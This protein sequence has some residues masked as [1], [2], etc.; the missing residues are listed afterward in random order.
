MVRIFISYSEDDGKILAKELR[1]YLRKF[2]HEVFVARH[3]I[4][5]GEIW[6]QKIIDSLRT[7]DIFIVLLTSAALKSGFVS[8]EITMAKDLNKIIIPCKDDLL[9][10]SWGELPLDLGDY[11]GMDFH[12]EDELKRRLLNQIEGILKNKVGFEATMTLKTEKKSYAIGETIKVVGTVPAIIEEVPVVLQVF[13]PRNWR[14]AEEQLLPYTDRTFV[15]E[16]LIEGMIW[17]SGTYNVRATYAG[18]T[19]N[20]TFEFT[21]EIPPEVVRATFSGNSVDIHA[22]LSNGV[23]NNVE[24]DPDFTSIII[25]TTTSRTHQGELTITL[26]RNLIDT[27]C[28]GSGNDDEFIILIDGEE[29]TYKE[30]ETTST[31]RTLLIQVPSGA[32]EIEIIGTQVTGV[33]TNRS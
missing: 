6:K 24:V 21:K 19:V 8:M 33:G 4:Q 31:H 27:K 3:D 16:F 26:P 9:E 25:C 15:F 29:E 2:D 1:G 22:K 7:C 17:T 23:M 14:Y 5:G 11:Q 32:K 20:T 30:T 18:R 12:D 13:D 28:V 10:K